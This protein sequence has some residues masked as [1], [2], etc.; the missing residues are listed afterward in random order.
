MH[1]K[2]F[3]SVQKPLLAI[4]EG[5]IFREYLLAE[6]ERKNYFDNSIDSI[7]D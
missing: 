3:K 4:F 2:G 1:R 7:W 6:K 5:L